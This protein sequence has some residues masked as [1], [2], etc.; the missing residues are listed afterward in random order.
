MKGSRCTPCFTNSG[1]N[2]TKLIKTAWSRM[3]LHDMICMPPAFDRYESLTLSFGHSHRPCTHRAAEGCEGFSKPSDK[4]NIAPLKSLDW[5]SPPN[6][7]KSNKPNYCEDSEFYIKVRPKQL[8]CNTVQLVG[9]DVIFID[10][11]DPLV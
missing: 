6:S 5:F 3:G 1:Q 4:N 7:R 10:L 9:G 8:Q 2:F 11:S